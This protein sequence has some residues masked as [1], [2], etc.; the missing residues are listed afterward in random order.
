MAKDVAF[1]DILPGDAAATASTVLSKL[2]LNN[3]DQGSF[4]M[5]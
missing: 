3:K 4:R 5:C 1:S 2:A